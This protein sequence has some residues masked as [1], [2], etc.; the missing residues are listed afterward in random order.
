MSHRDAYVAR[1]KQELDVLNA[2]L[3]RLDAKA[4]EARQGAQEEMAQQMKTLRE[5]STAAAAKLDELTAAGS[6]SWDAL[7]AEMDKLR[8]AF[9]HSFQ[10]FKS[11]V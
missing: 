10:Y 11:Q 6:D 5:H 2:D 3:T 4:R 1:M 8:S 7:V 9:A